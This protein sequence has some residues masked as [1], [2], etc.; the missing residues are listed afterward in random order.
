MSFGQVVMRFRPA[1]Q[2]E[3]S[4]AKRQQ[5]Q[6]RVRGQL[7]RFKLPEKVEKG[8]MQWLGFPL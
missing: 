1:D 5:L 6:R 7:C 4:Q 8:V 2:R 3:S